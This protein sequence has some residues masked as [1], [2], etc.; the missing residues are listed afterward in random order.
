MDDKLITGGIVGTVISAAG[1][2]L[3]VTE[4]QAII[5]II[6]TVLGFIISVIIPTSIKIYNKIKK[7]KEDG[8]VTPEERKEIVDEIVDGTKVIAEEGKT[9]IDKVSSMKEEESENK[10]EGD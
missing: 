5:S 8:V 10:S 2:G 6:I 4:L 9:I 1:A 7:A 3:S